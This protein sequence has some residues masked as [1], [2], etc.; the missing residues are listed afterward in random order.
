MRHLLVAV[1][2]ILAIGTASAD[3]IGSGSQSG[4]RIERIQIKIEKYERI[5]ENI[6]QEVQKKI[7]NFN[8]LKGLGA[9]VEN[10]LRKYIVAVEECNIDSYS[11]LGED[12]CNDM[13]SLDLGIEIKKEKDTIVELIAQAERELK[14]A[15][16]K[17]KDIPKVVRML[18]ALRST[19]AMLERNLK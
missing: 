12:A 17:E 15:K 5:I 1:M 7:A 9:K 2:V 6:P 14:N 13:D 10:V 3:E 18:E 8:R 4:S 16:L 19:K 11:S